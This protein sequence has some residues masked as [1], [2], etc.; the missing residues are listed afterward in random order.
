VTIEVSVAT[1]IERSPEDVF[2]QVSAIDAW[3]AWL[4]ASGITAV[5]RS[6]SGPLAHGERLVVDQHVAGRAGQFAAEV[7]D[8]EPPNGLAIRGRDEDGILIELA[9]SL[10]PVERSTPCAGRSGSG[11]RCATGCSSRSRARR[12]NDRRWSISKAYGFGWRP[13]PGTDIRPYPFAAGVD[14]TATGRRPCSSHRS[15]MGRKGPTA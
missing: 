15:T 8:F 5:R 11:C 1:T 2:E 14:V 9:A 7:T 3:P 12:S 10:T 6:G 13:T 4:I